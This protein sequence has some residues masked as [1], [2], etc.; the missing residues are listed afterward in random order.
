LE[1]LRQ[2]PPDPGIAEAERVR[3]TAEAERTRRSAARESARMSGL[4]V[5]L[6]GTHGAGASAPPQRSTGT[7]EA[8]VEE[9]RS[10]QAAA[11]QVAGSE[12]RRSGETIAQALQ[13]PPSAWMLSAGTILPA[14][15]ITGLNSDLPGLVVAQVTQNV[16]DSATGRSVLVPQGARLIGSYDAKV[17]FGQRRALIAWQSIVFPDG[18]SV[19]LDNA[20]ATDLAGYAGVEDR[21]NF[22]TWRLMK[23]IALSSL[24]GVG[25]ELSLGGGESELVRAVRE[26]TQQNAAQAGDKITA[27]NLDIQPTLTARLAG[28]RHPSQEPRPSSVGSMTPCP[29]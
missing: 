13:A 8:G 29:T 14:S 15:L 1:G 18:S 7:I 9:V 12:G 28:P 3:E 27:R 20:P 19:E 6:A 11:R 22:H 4:L 25:T 2:T 17:S 5:Q 24:L 26:A 10:A 23:G 16:R 21:V